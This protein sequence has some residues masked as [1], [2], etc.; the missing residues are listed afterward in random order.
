MLDR[1]YRRELS[2]LSVKIR[3]KPQSDGHRLDRCRWS[4]WLRLQMRAELLSVSFPADHF[5][6]QRRAVRKPEADCQKDPKFSIYL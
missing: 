6:K 2:I 3:S 1:Y 5:E 4:L